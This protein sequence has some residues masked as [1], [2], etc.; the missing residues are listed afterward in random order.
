MPISLNCEATVSDLNRQVWTDRLTTVVLPSQLCLGMRRAERSCAPGDEVVCDIVAT[1]VKGDIKVGTSVDVEINEYGSDDKLLNQSKQTFTIAKSPQ[2]L[3]YQSSLSA[4]RLVINADALDASGRVS[5]SFIDI[6][7]KASGKAKS[8]D[9]QSFSYVRSDH[10]EL[11]MTAD[12]PSYSAGDIAKVT[13]KSPVYPITGLYMILGGGDRK[14]QPLTISRAV[15]E[16]AVPISEDYYPSIEVRVHASVNRKEFAEGS[17]SLDVPP[18]RRRLSVCA[19]PGK[20]VYKPGERATI[21]VALKDIDLKPVPAAQV[22][23]MVVDDSVLALT[24]SDAHDPLDAF[25]RSYLKY[26]DRR[27][28]RTQETGLLMTVA[29][30][31]IV[32]GRIGESGGRYLFALSE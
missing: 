17:L 15:T 2:R 6:K 29:N 14:P 32:S 26:I 19:T 24:Y 8:V 22:A 1:D 5:K 21:D 23:V 31:R 18:L 7:L 28:S 27:H 13:I 12:K 25:Y 3:K 10:I 4:S 16:I 30:S 11:K 20:S 9:D